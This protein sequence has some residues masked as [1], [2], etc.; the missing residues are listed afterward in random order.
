MNNNV[1]QEYNTV[2]YLK[3]DIEM[4]QAYLQELISQ[5]FIDNNSEVF[6]NS[7]KALIGLHGSIS[8]FAQKNGIK[9]TDIEQL[10]TKEIS[11]EFPKIAVIIKA[12]GFDIDFRLKPIV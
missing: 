8:D 1:T 2:D 5:Y 12:L 11:P 6:L 10:L 3:N 9:E 7:L 4:Q